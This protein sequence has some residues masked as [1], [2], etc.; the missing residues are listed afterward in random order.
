VFVCIF[1]S[2]RFAQYRTSPQQQQQ[3]QQQQLMLKP[4][5][6]E[7]PQQESDPL[8]LGREWLVQDISNALLHAQSSGVVVTGLPG[9][10]KTAFVLQLVEHSCFG[11]LKSNCKCRLFGGRL[12]PTV[13][14][15]FV[16]TY[17]R[18]VFSVDVSTI[19][20]KDRPSL[21]NSQTII[22]EDV[23]SLATRVVAYHFCQ[24][25]NNSTCLIPEFVHSLAAQLCQAP[26]LNIYRQHVLTE[27]NLQVRPKWGG[28]R[29]VVNKQL[30]ILTST[31]FV[32]NARVHRRSRCGVR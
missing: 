10:G 9:T 17:K 23:K 25:D 30:M 2:V 32:V 13:C 21:K 3:L 18:C 6:F 8:F 4:L 1:F 29:Q 16:H 20:G 28:G 26:Q 15:I 27:L 19:N 24:A 5:F 14:V 7:V 22:S 11:R 31:G 12:R